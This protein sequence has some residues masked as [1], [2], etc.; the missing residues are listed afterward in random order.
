MTSDDLP[1]PDPSGAPPAPDRSSAQAKGAGAA[2][3]VGA[4]AGAAG[5]SKLS[6]AAT[7]AATLMDSSTTAGEKA[8]AALTAGASTA[9]GGLAAAATGGNV[10]VGKAAAAVTDKVAKSETGQKVVGFTRKVIT[11]N[12]VV[13][14][15]GGMLAAFAALNAVNMAVA[16]IVSE[17]EVLGQ[18]EVGGECVADT[19]A[20]S[21]VEGDGPTWHSGGKLT[22]EHIGNARTIITVGKDLDVPTYGIIIALATAMQESTLVNLDGGDRD[23]AGLF[24]QRPS[25]GW[26]DIDEITDPTYASTKFYEGLLKVTGWQDMAVTVAAQ[27]VQRSGHPDAYAKHEPTARAVYAHVT[28]SSALDGCGTG[29]APMNCPALVPASPEKGLTPDALNLARC[30]A[31][32]YSISAGNIGGVGDRPTNSKSDHPAGRAVDLMVPNWRTTSKTG[33]A[34]AS[35]IQDNAA[36]FGVNYIIW[37]AKYWYPSQPKDQWKPYSHPSGAT[38]ATSMHLDHVHVSVFG[39]AGTGLDESSGAVTGEWA[40]PTKPGARI[41]SP[42][43]MR[44]HPI[45]GYQKMHLGTDFGVG[46]GTPLYAATGGTVTRASYWGSAGNAVMIEHPGGVITHYFHLSKFNVAVGDKVVAGQQ[47]GLAGATGGVTG[48]HLHFEMKVNGQYID[49]APFLRARGVL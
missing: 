23:S 13:L 10:A 12:L 17:E 43:G 24:Q 26:G 41:T 18:K 33:D 34:W 29:G 21:T 36:A 6:S 37:D 9:V 44:R 20:P 15:V 39:N 7:T 38:D 22:E 35:W 40:F 25:Q 1:T 30:V 31:A 48:P 45:L 49:P 32:Q 3:A 16:A 2:K 27:T 4:V 11:I 5:Q 28:G 14:L 46:T 8:D 47:I 19:A 42:Y